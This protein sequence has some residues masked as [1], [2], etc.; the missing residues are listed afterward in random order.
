MLFLFFS[1]G[2]GVVVAAGDLVGV[3]TGAA[4]VTVVTGAVLTKVVGVSGV[5]KERFETGVIVTVFL[6]TRLLRFA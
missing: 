5:E 1:G 4:V 2:A 3:P 6:R